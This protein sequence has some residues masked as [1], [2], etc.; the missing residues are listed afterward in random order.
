[1]RSC[2]S[3][4]S[5]KTTPAASS[6][7]SKAAGAR[8]GPGAILTNAAR[9]SFSTRIAKRVLTTVTKANTGRRYRGE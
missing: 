7:A 4:S 6:S 2:T 5:P 1:M 8:A 9:P 3:V